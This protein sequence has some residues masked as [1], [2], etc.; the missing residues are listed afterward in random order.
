MK[1][2]GDERIKEVSVNHPLVQKKINKTLDLSIKEAGFNSA[3]FNLR[4]AFLAPFA[5]A[6]NAT[7]SQIGILSGIESLFP[8]ITQFF[9]C[10]LISNSSNTVK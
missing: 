4:S 5:L 8:A 9:S 1:K 3:H 10:K 6:M 2:K 7:S